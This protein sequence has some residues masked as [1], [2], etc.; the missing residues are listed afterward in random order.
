[1]CFRYG[2]KNLVLK[3]DNV[4]VYLTYSPRGEKLQLKLGNLPVQYLRTSLETSE[5]FTLL[6][7]AFEKYTF[8]LPTV[9]E[10]TAT[11]DLTPNVLSMPPLSMPPPQ[12]E[13]SSSSSSTTLVK[14][15]ST[16]ATPSS[17]SAAAQGKKKKKMIEEEEKKIL[18]NV[19]DYVNLDFEESQSF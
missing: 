15:S 2:M 18:F 14:R 11:E 10:L 6:E 3:G 9:A 16:G 8:S 19:E 7:K 5:E 4:I 13:A 17:S 12:K 1:M